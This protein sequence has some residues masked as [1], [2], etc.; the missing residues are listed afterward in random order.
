MKNM[1]PHSVANNWLSAAEI[2]QNHGRFPFF[3][4]SNPVH[5][6]KFIVLL[7]RMARK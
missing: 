4:G 3:L 5:A 2:D 6:T 7:V 1:F